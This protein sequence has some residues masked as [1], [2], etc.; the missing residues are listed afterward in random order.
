MRKKADTLTEREYVFCETYLKTFNA[1]KAYKAAG[2][3]ES[4]WTY[5]NAQ[6]VLRRPHIQAYIKRR[7]AEMKFTTDEV[8]IRLQQQAS[9][10]MEDFLRKDE[11][12]NV[13]DEIDFAEAQKKHK[14]HLVKKFVL[15]GAKG[16]GYIE[17]V[18]SQ[19]ALDKVAR[20]LKM[21]G[22]AALGEQSDNPLKRLEEMMKARKEKKELEEAA[23][24]N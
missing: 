18:D 24:K 3:T 15:P 23:R 6:N 1:T 12:G 11:N 20:A 2:Y 5:K 13:M 22:D 21:Y 17:L 8:L 4:R 19:A 14:L 10:S 16:G 7:L 9:V